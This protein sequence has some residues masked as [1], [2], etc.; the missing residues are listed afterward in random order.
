MNLAS[1]KQLYETQNYSELIDILQESI[2]YS[3][4]PKVNVDSLTL[5]IQVQIQ[6]LL[7][8]Y[9]SLNRMEECMSFAEKCLFYSYNNFLT[10]PTE[11][12]LEEWA[13][14]I[15]FCLVYIEAIVRED[16]SEMLFTLNDKLQRL[17]QT[18]TQIISNQLDV[19]LD[20]NCPKVNF[21]NFFK[22]I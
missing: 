22:I 7:E 10:A 21:F 13:E 5:K 11:F 9:F 15:N 1:V 4:G 17:V 6:I 16:G 20:K 3:T 2:I 18:L 12:R 14:L 19:P 8:A